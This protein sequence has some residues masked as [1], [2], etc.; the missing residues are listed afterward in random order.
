MGYIL[1]EILLPNMVLVFPPRSSPTPMTAV[2]IP[3]TASAATRRPIARRPQGNSAACTY[4]QDD[5]EESVFN[6]DNYLG[7]IQ[8]FAGQIVPRL[9][10]SIAV[11]VRPS[12]ERGMK[13]LMLL[14]NPDE[15]DEAVPAQ[16]DQA[17]EI[18]GELFKNI[19]KYFCV[20]EKEEKK[21]KDEDEDEEEE[22][23]VDE[24]K[25]RFE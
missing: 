13:S 19:A 3:P 15:Y 14:E 20:K 8:A 10:L 7:L 16:A 18:E 5:V 12:T 2:L 1:V 21:D 17:H 25:E 11:H 22:E 6:E 9:H 4:T 24:S 23:E